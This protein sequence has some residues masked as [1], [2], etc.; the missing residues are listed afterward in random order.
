MDMKLP[1][2][3]YFTYGDHQKVGS[4]YSILVKFKRYFLAPTRFITGKLSQEIMENCLVF[5]QPNG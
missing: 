5:V 2:Y 4:E 3:A 1:L